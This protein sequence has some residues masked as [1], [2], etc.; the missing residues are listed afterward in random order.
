MRQKIFPAVTIAVCLAIA[1]F[2]ILLIYSPLQSEISSL[3]LEMRRIQAVEQNLSEFKR[4][5]GEFEKFSALIE[6]RLNEAQKFLPSTPAQDI[7]VAELYRIAEK[8]NVLINSVQIGELENVDEK[9]EDKNNVPNEYQGA[10]RFSYMDYDVLSEAINTDLVHIQGT[11]AK[12]NVVFSCID[13][14]GDAYYY[15][16]NGKFSNADKL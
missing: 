4:R 14:L 15:Y 10:L 1:I 9:V 16:N 7:F 8:N 5:H 6:N 11:N 12:V 13:Q 3:Q 2:F